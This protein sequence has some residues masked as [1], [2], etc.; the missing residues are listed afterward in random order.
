MSCRLS[1]RSVRHPGNL[2]PT[3]EVKLIVQKMDQLLYHGILMLS[4]LKCS[5]MRR[6]SL[7]YLTLLQSNHAIAAKGLVT[8]YVLNAMGRVG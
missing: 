7:G 3:L 5:R 2:F 6:N 8:L 1:Q 4:L